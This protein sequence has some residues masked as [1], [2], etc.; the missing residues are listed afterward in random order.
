MACYTLS[1]IDRQILGTFVG[2]IK[3]DFGLSD[4]QFGALQGF[5][6][7]VF[8]TFIGL[9][10]GYWIDKTNRRNLIVLGVLIWSFF[11]TSCAFASSY[12][13]LLISRMGVGIG[14]ATLGP[15]AFS[16]MADLFPKERMGVAASVFY[17]GNLVGAG[18]ALLIGG[19]VR[20]AVTT[21]QPWHIPFMGDV[22]GWRLVFVML[23]IPGMI[24]AFLVFTVKEPKRTSLA[25]VGGEKVNPTPVEAL[26]EM[27][28]RWHSVVGISLAFSFQAAANYGFMGWAT[29][30]F[31]RVHHWGPGQT[32]RALGTLIMTCGVAG[33]YIGGWIS[34]RLHRKGVIDAPLLVSIPSAIGIVVF[35]T[36]A[37]LAPTP[38]M[39]LMFAA[40][41]LFTIALP[42]GVASASL[43][44]IFPNQFRGF[45]TA[46]YLF[47]LNLGGLPIGNYVPG[48]LA[49]K[50]FHDPLKI[51]TSAA[52]TIGVCGTLML[53]LILA[54]RSKYREHYR[55]MHSQG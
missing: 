46:L 35:L 52:I 22:I 34:D 13:T 4:S 18:L 53:L 48:L 45:V 14:E 2:P 3:A 19:A 40:P 43:T 33:L 25:M 38:E 51:G 30:F 5:Y 24:F 12:T 37:M 55:M 16:I 23:G 21:M 47:I 49:D 9:P 7:A 11:T 39:S 28:K 6:F 10:L 26:A 1:Y 44:Y 54:T 8:Y 36:A 17:W 41:G 27:R 32:T 50:F 42:M 15:A 29:E 31:L 20:E